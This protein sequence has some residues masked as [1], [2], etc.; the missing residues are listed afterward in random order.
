MLRS[1]TIIEGVIVSL[2]FEC[3]LQQLML[4]MSSSTPKQLRLNSIPLET[5][6]L[7]YALNIIEARR[8]TLSMIIYG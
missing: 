6:R 4:P 3:A 5:V 8:Y 2:D 7:H 1:C